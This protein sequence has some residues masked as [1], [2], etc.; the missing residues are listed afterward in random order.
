MGFGNDWIGRLFVQWNTLRVAIRWAL[1]F[2]AKP[3][4]DCLKALGSAQIGNGEPRTLPKLY[5]R[6]IEPRNL[7]GVPN[8]PG[9]VYAFQVGKLRALSRQLSGNPRCLFQKKN[10]I[11]IDFRGRGDQLQDEVYDL[12]LVCELSN[13]CTSCTET[14]RLAR[15]ELTGSLKNCICANPPWNHIVSFPVL[16][17]LTEI[18][19]SINP[20]GGFSIVCMAL[21][22][23]GAVGKSHVLSL[24]STSPCMSDLRAL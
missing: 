23:K 18:A 19:D 10:S 14:N 6:H 21:R 12:K 7:L 13:I 5:R 24:S 3:G 8:S 17:M 11:L 20:Y 15:D 1:C 2:K 16:P 9:K 4:I 22:T